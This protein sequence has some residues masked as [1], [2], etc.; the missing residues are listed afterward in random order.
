MNLSKKKNIKKNRYKKAV[1]FISARAYEKNICTND[2]L[3]KA[4]EI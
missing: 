2:E 1:D 3:K 4:I